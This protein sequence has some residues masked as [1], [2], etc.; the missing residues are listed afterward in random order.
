MCPWFFVFQ[1]CDVAE[2]VTI[3]KIISQIWLHSRYESR[4]KQNPSIFLATY[5]T[6][7]KNLVTRGKKIHCK[8]A[9]PNKTILFDIVLHLIT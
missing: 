4:K 8:L 5:Q 2:V 9:L 3:H 6:H 7:H 1:F